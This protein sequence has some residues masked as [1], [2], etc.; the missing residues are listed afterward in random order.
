MY[1][2]IHA[3]THPVAFAGFWQLEREAYAGDAL[4]R[5]PKPTVQ[6][7]EVELGVPEPVTDVEPELFACA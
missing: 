3:T 1:V 2:S 4:A 5:A 7:L 6:R